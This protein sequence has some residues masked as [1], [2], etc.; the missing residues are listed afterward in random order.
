[1]IRANAKPVTRIRPGDLQRHCIWRFVS[2]DEPDET[3]ITPL[4]GATV[5]SFTGKVVG[6]KVV[7]ANQISHWAVFSNIDPTN[8]WLTRHVLTLSV[9]TG[10]RWFHLARYHD[11]DVQEHGP[12][13]LAAAFGLSVSD[14]FPIQY[15]LRRY[16]KVA[17]DCLVGVVEATPRKRLTRAQIIALAVP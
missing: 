11:P 9:W 15:D 5:S 10:R 16:S 7:F 17:S 3:W 8:G 4:K 2:S 12:N 14:V 13:A 6:T 1:M